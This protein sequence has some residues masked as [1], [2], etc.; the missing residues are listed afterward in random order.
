MFISSLPQD[1]LSDR[2]TAFGHLK[3]KVLFELNHH[4]DEMKFLIVLVRLI[5]KM[6][7]QRRIVFSNIEKW[8]DNKDMRAFA[9]AAS[10]SE[11]VITDSKRIIAFIK[12][13]RSMKEEHIIVEKELYK[14]IMSSEKR[15]TGFRNALEH[16]DRDIANYNISSGQ[17][18][19]LI[20]SENGYKINDFSIN[21]DE[22][23]DFLL[24]CDTYIKDVISK[25]GRIQ[26]KDEK[27]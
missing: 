6:F 18:F 12:A 9:L 24:D 22:L 21:Y 1:N 11:D 20:L 8:L 4:P 26:K 3:L 25:I 23:D 14:K 10:Y 2:K 5:D 19:G 27:N 17:D 15:I 16:L 7:D 13:H